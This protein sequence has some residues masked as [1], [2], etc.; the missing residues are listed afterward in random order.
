[1]TRFLND[2]CR[3]AL[4][5]ASVCLAGAPACASAGIL[6]PGEYR[7]GNVLPAAVKEN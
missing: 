6:V 2:V 5:V 7:A 3:L 1:V 4:P